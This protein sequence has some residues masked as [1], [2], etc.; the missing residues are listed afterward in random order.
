MSKY[1]VYSGPYFPVFGL[2]KIAYL[3]AFH[4]VREWNFGNFFGHISPLK[5]RRKP[6]FDA[7]YLNQEFNVDLENLFSFNQAPG[8]NRLTTLFLKSDKIRGFWV[9]SVNAEFINLAPSKFYQIIQIIQILSNH[10][11]HPNYQIIQIIQIIQ[12]S[13][14]FYQI[15]MRRNFLGPSDSKRSHKLS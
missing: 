13:S 3:Y 7:F 15:W 10:P 6:K 11:N 1:G 9:L 12:I 8:E 4:A 5:M 14:K 2:E